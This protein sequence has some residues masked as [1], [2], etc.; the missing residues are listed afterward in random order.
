MFFYKNIAFD[1]DRQVVALDISYKTDRAPAEA[2]RRIRR[3]RLGG[4][5]APARADTPPPPRRST[6]GTASPWPRTRAASPCSSRSATTGA[7]CSCRG[8]EEGATGWQIVDLTPAAAEG[9]R[10][11]RV[12]DLESR[13]GEI[14]LA[15]AFHPKGRP[16]AARLFVSPRLT[17][18]HAVTDWGVRKRWSTAY[19]GGA[20]GEISRILLGTSD[21]GQG[22]RS[23]SPPSRACARRRTCAS[24][25][26][27]TD[28]AG[29]GSRYH[30]PENARVLHDLAIGTVQGDRWR[31]R[32]LQP[33]RAAPDARVL[34]PAGPGARQDRALRLQVARAGA[35][36]RRPAARRS[37]DGSVPRRR[38]RVR[39]L[40]AGEAPT[41]IAAAKAALPD[42]RGACGPQRRRDRGK[43]WPRRRRAEYV[44]GAGAR[45][46]PPSAF[47]EDVAQFVPL[48]NWSRRTNQIFTVSRTGGLRY[49]WKD[50]ASVT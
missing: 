30:L 50:Q 20:S 10:R 23:A 47:D 49:R 3:G 46:P 1:E 12:R 25:V 40:D 2:A 44:E 32:A 6:P 31:V 27:A 9:A 37:L 8:V 38:R 19:G 28:A 21:D 15:A 17:H 45:G 39:F 26:D 48:R 16:D 24:N 11:R 22:R 7:S 14:Y 34:Q 4:A 29:R 18:N 35:R 43:F 5:R 41:T 42:V 13:A 33:E 36:H